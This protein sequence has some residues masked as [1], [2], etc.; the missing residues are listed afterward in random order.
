[1]KELRKASMIQRRVS[2]GISD[3]ML[4]LHL[5]GLHLSV[6]ETEVQDEKNNPTIL[7]DAWTGIELTMLQHS[8]RDS[9]K[10]FIESK[11]TSIKKLLPSTYNRGFH[12]PSWM[13]PFPPEHTFR[14]TPYHPNR[15][16]NPRVLR[17]MI[18]QEGQLAEQA[19]RRLTGVI[20]MNDNEILLDDQDDYN[21]DHWNNDNNSTGL[22]KV[23]NLKPQL[24]PHESLQSFHAFNDLKNNGTDNFCLKPTISLKLSLSTNVL[25]K[26]VTS[27]SEN[28]QSSE[29]NSKVSTFGLKN[30]PSNS[31]DIISFTKAE[32]KPREKRHLRDLNITKHQEKRRKMIQ[33]HKS[34]LKNNI[35]SLSQIESDSEDL[36]QTGTGPSPTIVDKEYNTALL[37]ISRSKDSVEGN[38]ISDIADT[39]IVNWERNRCS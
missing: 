23:Q 18:V 25:L 30:S 11:K 27:Q 2:P 19:L 3:V 1:M 10:S 31:F 38:Y 9:S 20:K 22:D 32:N 15:V 24:E 14:N 28:I 16:S 13:P 6:L 34:L 7:P 8:E 29:N 37:R 35:K 36:N 12:I 5:S 21:V 4:L 39:G 33:W 26:N 17:E